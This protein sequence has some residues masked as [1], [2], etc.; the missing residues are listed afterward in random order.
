MCKK[1]LKMNIITGNVVVPRCHDSSF[2]THEADR[3]LYLVCCLHC[4]S[5][6]FVFCNE[7]RPKVRAAH[8][9]YTV[10]DVA[11]ELGKRWEV[12]TDKS[13]FEKLAA[14]DRQRYETVSAASIVM[15]YMYAKL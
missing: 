12:V 13:K 6:F 11:K 15:I 5:A 8:P 9:E 4:R 14:A 1:S 7:E 2:R 3:R 10:G